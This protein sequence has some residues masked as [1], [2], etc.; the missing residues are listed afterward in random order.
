DCLFEYW[1]VDK[2][3]VGGEI[4]EDGILVG[5]EE[6]DG[7]LYERKRLGDSDSYKNLTS[8][9]GAI[10][11]LKAI[12]SENEYTIDFNENLDSLPEDAKVVSEGKVQ[13]ITLLNTEEVLAPKQESVVE[14]YILKGWDLNSRVATPTFVAGT[15]MIHGLGR[16]KGGHITL[17]GIWGKPNS[18][19][20]I[21][22]ENGGDGE[23]RDVDEKIPTPS[24]AKDELGN[25]F[26]Y[27]NIERVEENEGDDVRNEGEL[28]DK[29]LLVHFG[30]DTTLQEALGSDLLDGVRYVGYPVY[31]DEYTVRIDLNRPAG[32]DSSDEI[33]YNMLEQKIYR[34]DRQELFKDLS[35]ELPGFRFLGLSDVRGG[36][37]AYNRG[38]ITRLYIDTNTNETGNVKEL[39]AG[40]GKVITVYAVWEPIHYFVAFDKGNDVVIE[41]APKVASPIEKVYGVSY[42]DLR[43]DGTYRYN[44]HDFL[45]W[46]IDRVVEGGEVDSSGNVL[47]GE[48]ID[49]YRYERATFSELSSYK[50][51]TKIDGSIVVLKAIWSDLRY[52]LRFNQN[53]P[54]DSEVVKLDTNDYSKTL[55][56]NESIVAPRIT[57]VVKGHSFVGW[58]RDLAV[59]TP[60][61]IQGVDLIH[62]LGREAENDITLYG[63][64]SKDVAKVITPTGD[65]G[66]DEEH[67]ITDEIEKP[68]SPLDKDEFGND[69]VYYIIGTI[70]NPSRDRVEDDM[71]DKELLAKYNEDTSLYEALD[72]EVDNTAKYYSY[73]IYNN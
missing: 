71:T 27:Y 10:V 65:N 47:G 54:A 16:E 15:S 43:L 13:S 36:E 42:N 9:D 61:Y 33:T 29:E 21:P 12:W 34:D 26:L 49:G 67:D 5:G 31:A 14:G 60:T 56:N 2:V 45:Y 23:V 41:D 18:D 46:E 62:G 11:T 66:E 51:L 38:D 57:T 20:V 24:N 30:G 8:I 28:T 22:I 17:Y 73:P 25:N 44:S 19:V 35:I 7:Y 68:T 72:G 32:A 37:V 53:I 48:D 1:E 58:D 6:V 50:N 70:S 39:Y 59:S 4:D 63:I 69:F 55:Y 64:W 40:A 52:T 3:T